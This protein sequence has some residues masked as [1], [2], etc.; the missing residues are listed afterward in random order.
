[1]TMLIQVKKRGEENA[2]SERKSSCVGTAR[3]SR[4]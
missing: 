2:R 3:F 4:R 1:L